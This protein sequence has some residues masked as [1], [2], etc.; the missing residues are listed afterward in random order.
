LVAGVAEAGTETTREPGLMTTAALLTPDRLQEGV[1][2]AGLVA[3]SPVMAPVERGQANA[4]AVA[5]A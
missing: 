1:D 4:A 5:S 3:V 2:P